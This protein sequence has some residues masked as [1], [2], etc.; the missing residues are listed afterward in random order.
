MEHDVS[1]GTGSATEEF[2][3][4]GERTYNF[5]FD[6]APENGVNQFEEQGKKSD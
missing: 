6:P 2:I 4:S 3:K 1:S 5:R